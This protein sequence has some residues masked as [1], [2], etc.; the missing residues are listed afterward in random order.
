MFP[1]A[2]MWMASSAFAVAVT[3]VKSNPKHRIIKRIHVDVNRFNADTCLLGAL[4]FAEH[5]SD[6]G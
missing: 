2:F 3:E 6:S 4:S 5:T 1:S